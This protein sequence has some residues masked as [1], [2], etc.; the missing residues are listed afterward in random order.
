[1]NALR[2]SFRMVRHPG[3]PE[4]H[5]DAVRLQ[6]GPELAYSGS[7]LACITG[8]TTASATLCRVGGRVLLVIHSNPIAAACLSPDRAPVLLADVAADPARA[9]QALSGAWVLMFADEDEGRFILA[10]DRAARRA[11]CFA[12]Y[13]NRVLFGLGADDVVALEPALA[14]IDPQAIFGYLYSHVIVA[15]Q[16]VYEHVQRLRPGEFLCVEREAVRRRCY[17]EPTYSEEASPRGFRAA[18]HELMRLLESSVAQEIGPGNPGAFLSG[19]TDSSTLAGMLGRVTGQPANTY[20]IGFDAE[21]FDEMAYAR[22]AAR[23]FRTRHREYYVTPDDIVATVP[24]IAHAYDQPF[25]N[26]SA[27]P[28]F[29]C[30]HMAKADGVT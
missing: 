5:D 15:P 2:G 7:L 3:I 16:T 24:L 30:A 12:V 11:P 1:M 10:T 23:H 9:L 18:R 13:G 8:L 4:L 29:L 27:L 19:G 6:T 26:S 22:I 28:A 25:G 17:W 21:G 20:S 14:R